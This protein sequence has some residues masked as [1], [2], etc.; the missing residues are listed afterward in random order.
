MTDLLQLPCQMEKRNVTWCGFV[1]HLF[2]AKLEE[3]FE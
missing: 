1:F 3:S 2:G